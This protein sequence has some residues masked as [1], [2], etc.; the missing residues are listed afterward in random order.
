MKLRKSAHTVYR[1]Q[2]HIVWI[3]RFRRKIFI[4]GVRQYLGTKFREVRKYYPEWEYIA[5]GIAVDHVH[6]HMMKPPKYLVSEVVDII[7]ANTS[8]AL[9]EKF[10]FLSKVY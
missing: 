4:K 10:G 2:Y 9:R 6:I 8:G 3:T 1:T 5:I 7:K